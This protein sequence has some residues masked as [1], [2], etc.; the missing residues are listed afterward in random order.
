VQQQQ[1]QPMQTQAVYGAHPP[2]AYP[3]SQQ[4]AT[5]GY[6]ATPHSAPPSSIF[7]H[8]H[9]GTWQHYSA[10]AANSMP[11]TYTAFHPG[12]GSTTTTTTTGCFTMQ[13]PIGQQVQ[14]AEY[15]QYANFMPQSF[16]IRHQQQQLHQQQQQQTAFLQQQ[17]NSPMQMPMPMPM[18]K[19]H[20]LAAVSAMH[21]IQQHPSPPPLSM[22][23][24]PMHSSQSPTTITS[25][26]YIPHATIAPSASTSI[27]TSMHVQQSPSPMLLQSQ[28]SPTP[29][30]VRSSTKPKTPPIQ[31]P[32]VV[33]QSP[34]PMGSPLSTPSSVSTSTTSSQG[35]SQSMLRPNSTE[36]IVTPPGPS[37]AS[38]AGSVSMSLAG[39]TTGATTS[40]NTTVGSS[41]PV[42][43]FGPPLLTSNS[44]STLSHGHSA[45]AS[46]SAT[47]TPDDLQAVHASSSDDSSSHDGGTEEGHRKRPRK[48]H[49]MTDRQRRAKIKSGMEALKQL[50]AQHVSLC[51]ER[52]QLLHLRR[53]SRSMCVLVSHAQG[54]YVS[55]QVSI[56][57]SSVS[58]LH[59]LRSEM[60]DLHHAFDQVIGELEN[61]RNSLVTTQPAM[62]T[63]IGQRVQQLSTNR[64]HIAYQYTQIRQGI[65]NN[66]GPRASPISP[67]VSTLLSPTP[68]LHST[69][70]ISGP[71]SFPP[72]PAHH[73]SSGISAAGMGMTPGMMGLTS[74]S[75]TGVRMTL[76]PAGEIPNIPPAVKMEQGGAI[77]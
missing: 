52:V 25:S 63:A 5:P 53:F 39:M 65:H 74:P 36:A 49:M 54:M 37:G 32:E 72:S 16:A 8:P 44:S 42:M 46:L 31:V 40:A 15:A 2:P 3:S 23:H 11:L 51:T 69:P 66:T 35:A 21:T 9:G 28:P 38:V 34:G 45:S 12:G 61:V 27:D 73:H 76:P 26:Q 70:P 58:L 29:P 57:T 20:H 33:V 41:T 75:W 7:D 43:G 64:Q 59:S 68:F 18:P 50:L 1:Q 60:N 6:Y 62:S 48:A 56:M 19:H 10:P 55:D 17:L 4:G 24:S 14:P 22:Y 67:S 47:L 13:P 77:Q 30:S 71:G